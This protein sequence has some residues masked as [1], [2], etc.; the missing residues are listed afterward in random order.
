MARDVFASLNPAQLK[1]VTHGEGPLLILAGAGSGKTRVLTHRIA[2]LIQQYKVSPHEILAM[3]FTNKAAREMRSRVE[4]L[5]GIPG[6]ILWVSTFHSTCVRILRREIERFGYRSDFVIYDESDQQTLVRQCIKQ[7]N[8]DEKIFG[9]KFFLS[10][11]EQAKMVCQQPEQYK[12]NDRQF[13]QEMVQKFYSLYQG[14]LRKY[15]ALDFGDLL[16]LTVKLFEECP[17][18]LEQYQSKFPFIMVDEYQDTNHVQYLF[19]RA[20]AQKHKNIAVVGDEDQS[21]YGWRGADI[22]NILSF[23]SDFP[24]AT[25]IKLEQNYRST[26]KIIEAASSLITINTQRKPK[27]LWTENP[28]GEHITCKV[29]YD[30]HEEA[31]HVVGEIKKWTQLNYS[32]NDCAIF[33]RTHAQSRVIEDELRRKGLPYKIFGGFRFY[34]RAEIKNMLAYLRVLLNPS[35]TISLLRV[36]NFPARGIGTTTIEKLLEYASLNNL[37]LWQSIERCGELSSGPAKKVKVFHAFISRLRLEIDSLSLDEL[38]LKILDEIAYIQSLKLEG[39]PE[40]LSRIENLE[41]L[42]EVIKEFLHHH[43]SPSLPSFLEEV[44]LITDLDNFDP[45]TPCVNLMTLHL[46]KGLEFPVVFMVGMEEGLFPH[47]SSAYDKD[48]LEEERRLCYV[49]MTRAQKKLYMTAAKYRHVYGIRQAHALSRFIDE[50]PSEYLEYLD[51]TPS[52]SPAVKLFP[53]VFDEFDQRPVD[54]QG[55]FKIGMKVKHPAYGVGIIRQLEGSEET[56]KVIIQFQTFGQKKF[57]TK[58]AQLQRI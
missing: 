53:D 3:T 1:A 31:A 43:P 57:L 42:H 52:I 47:N 35:D 37:S 22:S 17:E 46:A 23:E 12:G 2:Y 54:E 29:A 27:T 44:S 33:Y 48:E 51:Q 25:V 15:N 32:L 14:E 38:Y 56:E 24:G 45:S 50:V 41:E 11:I 40:A 34:D 10:R 30:E 13:L 19:M 49:G 18:V 16:M 26:K 5:L 39:T 20:L 8:I 9:P 21:I 28:D 4:R 55:I 36:F 7:L 6:H 58:F